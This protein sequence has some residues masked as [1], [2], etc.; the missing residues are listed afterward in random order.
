MNNRQA[1]ELYQYMSTVLE[2]DVDPESGAERISNKGSKLYNYAVGFDDARIALWC[3]TTWNVQKYDSA[4][5][6]AFRQ[7]MFGPLATSPSYG[8]AK[9]G[10]SRFVSKAMLAER[11]I[12]AEARLIALE[13]KV[14]DLTDAATSPKAIRE[15]TAWAPLAAV[16]SGSVSANG[17]SK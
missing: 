9:K 2:V 12:A 13:K 15:V 6:R 7:K 1:V 14:D 4:H 3:N 11:L 16:G 5:V 10:G 17:A 8:G